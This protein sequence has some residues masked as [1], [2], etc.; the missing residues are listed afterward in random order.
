MGWAPLVGRPADYLPSGTVGQW[1]PAPCNGGPNQRT[2]TLEPTMRQ[3]GRLGPRAGIPKR[4]LPSCHSCQRGTLKVAHNREGARRPQCAKGK[5]PEDC[6]VVAPLPAAG[7]RGNCWLDTCGRSGLLAVLMDNA[8]CESQPTHSACVSPFA[9]TQEDLL[10]GELR[11]QLQYF[12]LFPS[13]RLSENLG[14]RL[15]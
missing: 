4:Q 10:D 11:F 5:G 3:R 9:G 12:P 7:C 2:A 14:K 8:F 15:L 13:I 1:L 6:G